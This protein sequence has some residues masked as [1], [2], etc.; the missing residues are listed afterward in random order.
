MDSLQRLIDALRVLPGVGQKSAQRMAFYLLRASQRERGSRLA[1]ALSEAMQQIR[2]CDRCNNFTE[3]PC[4]RLC[5]RPERDK[6]LLC[7]VEMPADL[8]AVE[9]SQTYQGTYYVLMGRISPLDG[10]GP[11]DIRLE[12][13][14]HLVRTEAIQEIILALSPSVEGRATAYFIQQ[15]LQAYPVRISQLAQGIPCSG[16]LEFLDA[17]TIGAALRNRST[18]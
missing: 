6:K 14:E 13:L 15:M 12:K 17:T 5:E 1:T 16:E 10:L 11:K 18:V 9:Q 4:C 2:H 7:V 3:N 8:C